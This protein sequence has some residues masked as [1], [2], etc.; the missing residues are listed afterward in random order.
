ME[1][2]A[3]GRRRRGLILAGIVLV[4]GIPVTVTNW[5]SERNVGREA[6][7]LAEDLRRAGRQID[8]V[9]VLAGDESVDGW[10]GNLD[11]PL[12]TALGHGDA[13]TGYALGNGGLS[14]SYEVEWGWAR[15]CVHLLLR[16]DAPVLTEISDAAICGPLRID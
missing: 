5:V 6:T 15:R 3:D 2:D 12:V 14:V 11:R 8:D 4:V 10:D 1:D 7:S 9:A 13:L 16:D